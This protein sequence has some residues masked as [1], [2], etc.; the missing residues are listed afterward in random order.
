ME[1]LVIFSAHWHG[2]VKA[3]NVLFYE[4]LPMM[5]VFTHL[6]KYSVTLMSALYYEHLMPLES[7]V[8]EFKKEHPEILKERGPILKLSA[9]PDFIPN[10][11]PNSALIR[12]SHSEEKVLGKLLREQYEIA[13]VRDELYTETK[14]RWRSLAP[15]LAQMLEK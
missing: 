7:F 2:L 10:L 3:L 6:S 12:R 5:C 13:F 9:S 8:N 14:S 15:E 1:E 4:G 11:E